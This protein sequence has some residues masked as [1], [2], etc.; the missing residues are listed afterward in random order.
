MPIV[1]T[2]AT[3]LEARYK[4]LG[5]AEHCSACRF[6]MPQGTCGRIIGPVS[7]EGW[8]KYY[9]REFVQRWQPGSAG[10]NAAALPPGVSL[11]LSFMTPG[12]LD[13]RIT[14]TRASTA[15]YTDSTG[16]MRTAAIN[17][18]RWDYDPVTHQL[19]GLLLK[20]ARTNLV[21]PS[22]VAAPWGGANINLVVNAG[23]APDGTNTFT[24]IA[25]TA[26]TA[27]HYSIGGVLTIVASQPYTFSVY[28]KAGEN[29]YLMLI[30]DNNGGVGTNAMFDLQTGTITQAATNNGSTGSTSAMTAAGNGVYRCRQ[31]WN[32]T[33]VGVTKQSRVYRHADPY[34]P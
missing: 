12:T 29:R 7:P 26:T 14:F 6:F 32:A 34:A 19:R 8:C 9:S 24:K 20:D 17:A 28:A 2:R 16:T 33:G 27:P 22:V 10:G 5:G 15:T 30:F 4:A 18:P 1:L 3:K 13:P 11:D 31:I 25:D 21:F 23:T